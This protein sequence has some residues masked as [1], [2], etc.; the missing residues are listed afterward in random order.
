MDGNS[1]TLYTGVTEIQRDDLILW[2]FGPHDILIA[3]IN[4]QNNKCRFYDE[5]ANGR[6][7]GRLKLND[8]LDL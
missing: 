3:K 2:I 6:F 8:R 5:K 1:V 7:R 4:R